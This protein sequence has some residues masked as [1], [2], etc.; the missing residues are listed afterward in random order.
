MARHQFKQAPACS[1]A[2]KRKFRPSFDNCKPLTDHELELGL[3]F[4][5]V[6]D[7]R[8]SSEFRLDHSLGQT[9]PVKFSQVE[10]VFR[11]VGGVLQGR[12]FIDAEDYS[13]GLV[14]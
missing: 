11:R 12:L 7:N 2:P 14:R 10:L 6:I 5:V 4:H 13:F 8:F 1:L 9:R 3:R